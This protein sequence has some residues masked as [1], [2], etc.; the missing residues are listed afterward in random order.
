MAKRLSHQPI[1]LTILYLM[2]ANVIA[3]NAT[4]SGLSDKVAVIEVSGKGQGQEIHLCPAQPAG[5]PAG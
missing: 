4:L 2:C 1:P 5:Q 3:K